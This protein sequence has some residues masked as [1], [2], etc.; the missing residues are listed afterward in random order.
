MQLVPVRHTP[1]NGEDVDDEIDRPHDVHPVN[2][3]RRALLNEFAQTAQQMRQRKTENDGNQYAKMREHRSPS[4]QLVRRAHLE[5]GA[6]DGDDFDR[7]S[8]RQLRTF[9]HPQRIADTRFAV[10]VDDG[11]IQNIFATD[12][13]LGATIQ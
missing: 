7:R 6:V 13:L 3:Y 2:L 11:A 5:R 9:D 12:I 1:P 10:T 4:G 8:S